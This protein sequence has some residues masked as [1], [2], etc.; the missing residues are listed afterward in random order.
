M[1]QFEQ[2]TDPTTGSLVKRLKQNFGDA[3]MEPDD[4]IL[5]LAKVADKYADGECDADDMQRA[6]IQHLDRLALRSQLLS[7]SIRRWKEPPV[8]DDVTCALTILADGIVR[9]SRFA[10]KKYRVSSEENYRLKSRGIRKPDVAIWQGSDL[11]AIL[12]CK[13]CLGYTRK[14]WED[15]YNKRVKEFEDSGLNPK[16]VIYFVI[17]ENSW[18]GFPL[19]DPRTGTV[20]FSLAKKGAWFGGGKMGEAPLIEAMIPGRMKGLVEALEDLLT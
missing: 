9:S 7:R 13:T 5:K 2:T 12:E 16:G 11:K 1:K 3:G 10:P 14:T 15:D 4:D 6:M 18:G 17:S 8:A 20:W 19:D